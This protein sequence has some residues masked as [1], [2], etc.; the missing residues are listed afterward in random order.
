MI[1]RGACRRLAIRE[2]APEVSE[3][4][5]EPA[6]QWRSRQSLPAI[7]AL[8]EA[9]PRNARILCGDFNVTPES[10]VVDS[11]LAAGMDHAHRHCAGIATCNSNRKGLSLLQRRAARDAGSAHRRWHVLPSLDEPSDHCR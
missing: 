10:V 4:R 6:R 1:R 5:A 2:H 7:E 3:P 9:G 11:L 8:A